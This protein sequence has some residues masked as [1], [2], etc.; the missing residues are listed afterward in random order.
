[1]IIF[2]DYQIMTLKNVIQIIVKTYF[3]FEKS[4]MKIFSILPIYE[5]TIFF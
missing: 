3:R 5:G 2:L 1:M 4:N